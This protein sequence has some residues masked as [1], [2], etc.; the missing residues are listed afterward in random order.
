MTRSE[1]NTGLKFMVSQTPL[2]ILFTF[3]R[4]IIVS[5]ISINIRNSTRSLLSI[6]SFLWWQSSNTASD[7]KPPERESESHPSDFHPRTPYPSHVW[8][9]ATPLLYSP[10]NSPAQNT[11][12]GTCSL[13]QG[14][15]P[16]QGLN[17]HLLY[18]RRILYQ[19]PPT[20]KAQEFW[21][22]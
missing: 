11:G 22:E 16:T 18:R 6:M 5:L 4:K 17:P 9:S 12:M 3:L 19:E 14:T 10:W 15:F 13:L 7:K 20:R 1:E 21:S 8:L 2:A